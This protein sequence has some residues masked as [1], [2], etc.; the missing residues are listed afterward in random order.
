MSFEERRTLAWHETLELHELT[1]FHSFGLMKLKRAIKTV[2]DAPLRELYLEAIL[3]IEK[4]LR[5]LVKFYPSTPGCQREDDER[6]LEDFY[7]GDLLAMSKALV[8]NYSIAITETAT[9]LLRKTLTNHLLESIRLHERVFIYM[10]QNRLY[11]AYDLGELVQNDLNNA[12]KALNM[13]Y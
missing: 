3:G 13:K 6:V 7:A 4:Q 1:A 9:P 10:Y 2:R 8:R 5:E 12:N 11:P